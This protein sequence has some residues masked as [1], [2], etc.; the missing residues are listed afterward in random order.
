MAQRRHSVK[1]GPGPDEGSRGVSDHFEKLNWRLPEK[2]LAQ[3][4]PRNE[5]GPH[6]R[7]RLKMKRCD[8]KMKRA[9]RTNTCYV[10]TLPTFASTLASI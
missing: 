6:E 9:I 7:E 2:D 1:E 4:E 8:D 3:E 10:I 5:F